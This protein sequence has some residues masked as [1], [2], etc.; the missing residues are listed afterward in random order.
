[1]TKRRDECVLT[2]A[3]TVAG[4]KTGD[5]QHVKRPEIP[6]LAYINSLSLQLNEWFSFNIQL[7]I[8]TSAA[9][10]ASSS[11]DVKRA[12]SS[13]DK[14]MFSYIRTGA[15]CKNLW[16]HLEFSDIN[17]PH[18]LLSIFFFVSKGPTLSSIY[19]FSSGAG[20]ALEACPGQFWPSGAV[21]IAMVLSH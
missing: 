2:D 8:F 10:A 4:R 21:P 7:K 20:A 6:P 3:F 11:C 1:M 15:K 18:K 12:S 13:R 19:C 14:L 16:T 17:Y 9:A 5:M